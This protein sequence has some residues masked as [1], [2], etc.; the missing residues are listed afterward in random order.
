MRRPTRAV[1]AQTRRRNQPNVNGKNKDNSLNLGRTLG[2][3]AGNAIVPGIG[4]AVGSVIGS[5]AQRLYRTITGSGDYSIKYNTLENPLLPVPTFGSSCIRIKNREYI[6]DVITSSTAGAF[7]I[8][9]FPLNP[10][11]NAT[12]PWLSKIASNFEQYMFLGVIFEYVSNS[13]DAIT[14]TNTALGKL[15]MATDYNAGNAPFNTE[16]QMLITEFSNFGKPA[17]NLLHAIE[18]SSD[19]RPQ[20]LNYVRSAAVPAGQ[21]VKTYDLGNTSFASIGQQGTNVN[22]GA[23]WVSYDVFLC[24]P[25]LDPGTDPLSSLHLQLN[26]ISSGNLIGNVVSSSGDMQFTYTSK[27]VTIQNPVAGARYVVTLVFELHQDGSF[28]HPTLEII[29]GTLAPILISSQTQTWSSAG[30]YLNGDQLFIHFMILAD[31]SI[32][33]LT[34]SYNGGTLPTGTLGDFMICEC[35][36]SMT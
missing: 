12:F 25:I 14:G 20:L 16:Q 13:G 9:T 30:S 28:A 4:G 17:V 8:E 23:L 33:S 11:L 6:G 36:P 18:C 35:D 10:G 3:A 31:N 5:A 7:K 27:S 19:Q 26:T 15:I 32:D 21:D 22:V 34:I 24:K 29:G 2:Y 1:R